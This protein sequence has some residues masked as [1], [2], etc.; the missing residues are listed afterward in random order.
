MSKIIGIHMTGKSSALLDDKVLRTAV[1]FEGNYGYPHF[2]G[3][4]HRI[5]ERVFA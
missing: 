4:Q 1:I 3:F 5:G 2:G